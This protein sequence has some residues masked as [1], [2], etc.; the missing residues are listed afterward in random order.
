[1]NIE[2]NDLATVLELAREH[3]RKGGG[4][5]TDTDA[6]RRIETELANAYAY[7]PKMPET[8]TLAQFRALERLYIRSADKAPNFEQFRERVVT[9]HLNGCLMVPW[10]GMYIGI[11]KDGH[12]HS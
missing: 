5:H 3:L 2:L 12:T 4:N 11:E 6:L 1:M 7:P 10:C 9:D 8:W